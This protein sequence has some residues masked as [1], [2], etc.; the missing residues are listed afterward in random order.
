MESERFAQDPRARWCPGLRSFSLRLD[1]P[2]GHS[3]NLV[4]DGDK[5][6][7]EIQGWRE[8]RE[9]M[10]RS[11]RSARDGLRSCAALFSSHGLT[12]ILES[13][14]KPIFRLGHNT[15]ASWLAR[16][17]GLAPAYIPVSAVGFFFR[18]T[19]QR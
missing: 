11:F 4:A 7:L 10:P 15:S 14:G 8:I 13:A 2:G 3:V 1:T 9:F 5:L 19:P 16:L 12:L 6:R 18:R 17:L